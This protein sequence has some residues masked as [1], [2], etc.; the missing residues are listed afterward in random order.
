MLLRRPVDLLTTESLSP[1]IG[2]RILD[3]AHYVIG[4]Y[5]RTGGLFLRGTAPLQGELVYVATDRSGRFVLSAYY[6]QS[7]VAVH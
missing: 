2:P 6:Y 4:G 1:Y 5:R 7:T 3:E